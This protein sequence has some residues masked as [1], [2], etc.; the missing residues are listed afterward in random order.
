MCGRYLFTSPLEA[1]QIDKRVE[2]ARNNDA[3]LIEQ[4]ELAG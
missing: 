3:G 1:Y 2:H 4:E